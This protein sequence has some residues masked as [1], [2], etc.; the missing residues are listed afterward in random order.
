MYNFNNATSWRP[1]LDMLIFFYSKTC[2]AF[3]FQKDTTYAPQ[4]QKY[5]LS[6]FVYITL[7]NGGN[8]S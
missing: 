5:E 4:I 8:S 2:P 3:E 6:G 7:D 1:S